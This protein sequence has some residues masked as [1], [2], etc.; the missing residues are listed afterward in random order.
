MVALITRFLLLLQGL[1]ILAVALACRLVLQLDWS[2]S[3]LMGLTLVLLVRMGITANNF[4]INRFYCGKPTDDAQLTW[5][6]WLRLYLTEFKT[7]M[8]CSS[9]TMPF[10]TFSKRPASPPSSLPVLLVH[11][12]GC[13]SG[14]WH[15]LSQVL[16]QAHITH[17]AI[18]LEPVFADIDDYV[19]SLREA[20]HAVCAETGSNQVIIVAHSMGGLAARAY[21][22]ADGD[23]KVAKVITLGSP[24]SG[25]GLANFGLGPNS[26]Q[27]RWIGSAR[28]GEA[29]DWLCQLKACE[30]EQ[31]LR[32]FV[33]LY[34]AH[35][36]IIAP[37][38][39][40]HLPGAKN[41]AFQGVGHVA[42]A[43]TPAVQECVIQEILASSNRQRQSELSKA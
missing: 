26:R 33:S 3:I 17:Y 43:H 18:D 34:S 41:I 37:Q 38:T 13:N 32:R 8:Y 15:S 20:I 40:S 4:F 22:R 10:F 42:L 19:P 29:S 6:E 28:Q 11:G 9:W 30:D 5:T 12:Y 1:L 35:D 25:T 31:R 39:S 21:L 14:Y 36:N 23:D 24:H 27:M 16:S 7:T 2:I